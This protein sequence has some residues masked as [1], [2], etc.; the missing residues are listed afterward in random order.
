MPDLRPGSQIG[1]WTIVR[2][3]GSGGNATVWAASRSST[4]QNALKVLN[5]SKAGREPY[6]RIVREIN[7][8]R[9]LK[10]AAGVLPLIEAYLP[11]QPTGQ[12]RPWL[13]MPIATGVGEALAGSSLELV[14]EALSQIASTLARLAQ[15]GV[16]TS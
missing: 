10:D 3:L 5:T 7:F 16:A 8:L 13:S 15:R 4:N 6:Q 12:D 9:E 14:I 1:P 11:D 2:L